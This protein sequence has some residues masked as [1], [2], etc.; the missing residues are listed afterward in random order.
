MGT[1]GLNQLLD[2]TETGRQRAEPYFCD[3]STTDP[4][5]PRRR[6][7][8]TP[9]RFSTRPRNGASMHLTIEPAT[10][11]DAHTLVAFERKVADPK[12]Y[13]P[14]LGVQGAIKEISE[15]TFYFIK[16]GDILVATAAYRL[17]IR[18]KRLY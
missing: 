15:N 16:R 6:D 18:Q 5:T 7:A 17:E 8:E 9:K 14:P 3:N 2:S 12:T 11:N 1:P 4:N 13:G 10:L